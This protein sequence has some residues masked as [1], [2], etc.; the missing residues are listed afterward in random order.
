MLNRFTCP[1]CG[2]V[3][4]ARAEWAG[5]SAKC[6]FCQ[7]PFTVPAPP[8]GPA[9]SQGSA[10]MSRQLADLVAEEQAAGV[11]DHEAERLALLLAQGTCREYHMVQELLAGRKMPARQ[12]RRVLTSAG[13]QELLREKVEQAA[14]RTPDQ[15]PPDD[16][17][18]ALL[19]ASDPAAAA[20]L[21]WTI[22]ARYLYFLSHGICDG[23]K[24]D[25]SGMSCIYQSLDRLAEARSVA[26]DRLQGWRESVRQHVGI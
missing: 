10:R 7:Q 8:T 5:R 4:K 16:V 22:L 11:E 13:A 23:C 6:P 15:D 14:A 12:W 18:I 9:G 20:E 3:I 2:K 19:V 24:N 25:V 17:P 26:P 1:S 21:A